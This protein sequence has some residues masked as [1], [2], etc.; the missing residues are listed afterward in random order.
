MM[1][2]QVM[3]CGRLLSRS[4]PNVGCASKCIRHLSVTTSGN[5]TQR[6]HLVTLKRYGS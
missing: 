3:E 5:S 4:L 6:D 2:F 1:R